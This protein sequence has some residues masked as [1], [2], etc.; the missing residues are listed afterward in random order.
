MPQI[1]NVFCWFRQSDKITYNRLLIAS[2]HVKI[3]ATRIQH[4][5]WLNMQV[6]LNDRI[7]SKNIIFGLMKNNLFTASMEYVNKCKNNWACCTIYTA[8]KIYKPN[9][10]IPNQ[11]WGGAN[12]LSTTVNSALL[13]FVYDIGITN[14]VMIVCLNTTVWPLINKVQCMWASIW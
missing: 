3:T 14:Y 10:R 2:F 13:L 4:N 12:N 8:N 7:R 1:M 11:K 9:Q 6:A 5:L